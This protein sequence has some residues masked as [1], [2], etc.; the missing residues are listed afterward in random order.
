MT[1][2]A[3]RAVHGPDRLSDVLGEV[4]GFLIRPA[5]PTAS[6]GDATRQVDPYPG[7]VPAVWVSGDN[8]SLDAV[9]E[10]AASGP[11]GLAV[12]HAGAARLDPLGPATLSLTADEAARLLGE[13]PVV[14]HADG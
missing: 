14:V 4:T 2:A 10:A 13:R 6:G 7:N 3:T 8:V 9:T 5:A 1:V 12:L 11:I